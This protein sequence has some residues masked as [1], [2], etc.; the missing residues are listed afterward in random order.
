MHGTVRAEQNK[1]ADARA[2]QQSS[3]HGSRGKG[4]LQIQLGKNNRRGAIGNK[5][6][7]CR[8]HYGKVRIRG[9]ERGERVFPNAVD[10]DFKRKR[11]QKYEQRDLQR[12]H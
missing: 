9:N 7:D 6:H 5:A 1:Q 3:E 4:A 11:N 12:M 8:N 2:Y 10:N